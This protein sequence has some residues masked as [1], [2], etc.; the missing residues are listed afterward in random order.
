LDLLL[1]LNGAF[2]L[3]RHRLILG[4]QPQKCRN[5]IDIAVLEMRV[6]ILR[7]AKP[8]DLPVEQPTKFEHRSASTSD[9]AR[10]A[11]TR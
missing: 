10:H 1:F 7:G 4:S 2:V 5:R 9:A 3:V 6:R 8:A 11:P